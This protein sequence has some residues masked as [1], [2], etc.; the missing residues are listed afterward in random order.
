MNV[1]EHR[2]QV[3]GEFNLLMKQIGCFR[4]QWICLPPRMHRQTN[5]LFFGGFSNV[6]PLNSIQIAVVP[7]NSR[8]F[9]RKPFEGIE[10]IGN[11][12]VERLCWTGCPAGSLVA[13]LDHFRFD[14]LRTK[15]SLNPT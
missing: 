14:A 11:R 7:S 2:T 15:S 3:P 9:V 12:I 4:M 13:N 1:Q 5:S 6:L 8:L 10:S